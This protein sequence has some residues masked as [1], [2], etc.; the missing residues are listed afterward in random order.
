MNGKDRCAGID[1]ISGHHC[2]ATHQAYMGSDWRY[3]VQD[4][5]ALTR[6]LM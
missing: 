5:L 2:F 6:F 1:K 3:T 4:V